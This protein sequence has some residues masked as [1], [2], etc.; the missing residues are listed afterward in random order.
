MA[1]PLGDDVNRNAFVEQRRLVGSAKIMDAETREARAA[2][3]GDEHCC[4]PIR[5]AYCCSEVGAD[6]REHQSLVW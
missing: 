6:G 4:H 3:V 1:A 5:A 2:R